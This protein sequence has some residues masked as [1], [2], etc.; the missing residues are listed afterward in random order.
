M[1]CHTDDAVPLED[2][3]GFESCLHA[4]APAALGPLKFHLLVLPLTPIIN[5]EAA[6]RYKTS[7][8]NPKAKLNRKPFNQLFVDSAQLFANHNPVN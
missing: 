7:Q 2:L 3:A 6:L 8:N 1:C 4:G 5:W